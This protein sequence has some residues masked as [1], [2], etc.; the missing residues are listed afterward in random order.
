MDAR[1]PNKP[2]KPD[3]DP[4]ELE[5]D[6]EL[7]HA[8][9]AT[10]WR[11]LVRHVLPVVERLV[12]LWAGDPWQAEELAAAALLRLYEK[13][14]SYSGS[15][16]FAAWAAVVTLNVCRAEHRL[17]KRDQT[18]PL[19]EART[20]APP[21]Q[22]GAD[23]ADERIRNQRA[24]ALGAA[25]DRLGKPEREAIVA[26]FLEERSTADAARELGV[27]ERVVRARVQ[28]GL[29]Q[30]RRMEDVAEL[31]LLAEAGA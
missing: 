27:T 6:L 30:L 23:E 22:E 25:V 29:K 9:E 31:M 24:M 14:A 11:D 4:P 12:G 10:Q 1:P 20:P 7:V 28:R 2:R 17:A 16:P 3:S 13:R 21:S 19:D 15:G 18:T 5:I 26:R 8:G